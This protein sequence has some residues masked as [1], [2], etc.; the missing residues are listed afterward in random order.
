MST[1]A[2]IAETSKELLRRIDNATNKMPSALPLD[3]VVDE[4]INVY[5][6]NVAINSAWRNQDIPGAQGDGQPATPLLP[7]NLYFLVSFYGSDRLTNLGKVMLN[8]HDHPILEFEAGSREIKQPDP[9]RITKHPLNMDETSKLWATLQS[10]YRTSV[11]YEVGIL[12]IESDNDSPTPLPVLSRGVNDSGWDSTSTFP[13]RLE[14]IK[15]PFQVGVPSGE[16]VTLIGENFLA[17]GKVQLELR[18]TTSND[19]KV[20]LPDKITS[21]EVS[22]TIDDSIQPGIWM[23]T[24]V[25]AKEKVENGTTTDQRSVSNVIPLAVLPIIMTDGDLVAENDDPNFKLELSCRPKL[26]KGQFVE[27][28]IG[29]T[30]VSGFSLTTDT[31]TVTAT[32]S[33]SVKWIEGEPKFAKLRVDGVDSL[34]FDPQK[35][36]LGFNQRLVVGGLPE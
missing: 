30:Q 33:N 15:S 29:S 4:A 27:V 25:F 2:A 21:G 6:Y 18:H 12:L 35:P 23:L 22:F 32:W 11:A 5:L 8:L 31:T 34:V 28:F 16:N 24:M 20:L 26:K 36:E 1:S 3:K 14:S 19:N 13:P 9:I 7:L 17:E 10:N